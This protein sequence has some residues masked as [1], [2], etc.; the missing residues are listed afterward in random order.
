MCLGSSQETVSGLLRAR[1][2]LEHLPAVPCALAVLPPADIVRRG[3]QQVYS[4]ASARLQLLEGH[5]GS[6]RVR[7]RRDDAAARRAQRAGRV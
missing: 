6:A 5:G 4:P 2:E 1:R 7:V 3:P